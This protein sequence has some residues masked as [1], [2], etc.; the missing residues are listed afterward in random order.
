MFIFG[1]SYSPA[2]CQTP[3]RLGRVTRHEAS[4]FFSFS[5]IVHVSLL[6][7]PPSLVL[8]ALARCRAYPAVP[9][10]RSGNGT[11]KPTRR[12]PQSGTVVQVNSL[13]IFFANWLVNFFYTF[14]QMG[15]CSRKT[16]DPIL[17]SLSHPPPL[18][19]FLRGFNRL[20]G[21]CT[22]VSPQASLL[23]FH[24]PGHPYRI[25]RKVKTVAPMSK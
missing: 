16:I 20:R 22:A 24:P 3:C 14:F 10:R 19:P 9:I 7:P 1:A 23:H 12:P 25:T 4:F 13:F 8:L 5:L 15:N 17:F 21:G 18:S 11:G 6:S 2:T